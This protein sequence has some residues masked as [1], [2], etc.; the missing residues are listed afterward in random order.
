VPF[1]LAV[2]YQ[3]TWPLEDALRPQRMWL[4]ASQPGLILAAIGLVAL[5]EVVVARRPRNDA[6]SR[7][8]LAPALTLAVI[9]IASLPTTVATARLMTGL[10]T[11]PGYAH[12]DL[13]QDRVPEMDRLLDVRGTRPVVLTYED[14]SS[15]VW[16]ETGAGVVAV[17]PPGYAKLAFDPEAFTGVS[18]PQRRADLA[19]A[20]DGDLDRLIATAD[21]Y[22]AD[23]IVLARRDGTVGLLGQPATIAATL[24]R[25][26]GPSRTLAG[27]GWDALVL[28]PGSS[29]TLDPAAPGGRMSLE[30]RAGIEG[31]TDDGGTAPAGRLRVRSGDG[32]PVELSVPALPDT[33]LSVV[34]A[35]LDR[36][37]GTPI[38]IEALDR[39]VLQGFT[40]FVADPGPPPGWVVATETDDAVVWERAP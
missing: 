18:Q 30:L 27:N 23:R 29:L 28:E 5:V 25:V 39:I 35:T 10:W 20:L 24:G 7:P 1:A 38:V 12:L 9:L 33:D 37:P 16:Y 26:D 31:V 6:A 4:L 19:M 32:A 21:R 8:R 17:E 3:P 14:W 34:T 22:G 36:A 13:A 15:L 11:E 2:L 40:G